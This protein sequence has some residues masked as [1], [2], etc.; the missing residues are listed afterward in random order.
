MPTASD[1]IDGV[2]I[3]VLDKNA[4]TD[5]EWN[6]V[7]E[8]ARSRKSE[9]RCGLIVSDG[10]APNA[11][12]RKSLTEQLA[13]LAHIPRAVVTPSSVVRG[14][15]TA[16]SWLGHNMKAFSPSE[17]Q[18]AVEFLH[19]PPDVRGSLV[20]KVMGMKAAIAVQARAS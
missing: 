6:A 5:S 7:L 11:I 16:L 20:E 18:Q 17:M 15:V 9:I 8:L 13:A 1:I 19:V 4:P 10:G 2:F 3:Q 12:Q 14:V